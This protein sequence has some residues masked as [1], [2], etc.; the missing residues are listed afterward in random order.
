[1]RGKITSTLPTQ[2]IIPKSAK[3]IGINGVIFLAVLLTWTRLSRVVKEIEAE[4]SD[5]APAADVEL[6]WFSLL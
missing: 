2:E 6:K 5:F 3:R 4:H 1:M